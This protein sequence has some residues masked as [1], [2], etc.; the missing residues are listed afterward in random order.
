[1][2]CRVKM[3]LSGAAVP[4][5][6][7]CVASFLMYGTNNAL[8]AISPL[9]VLSLGEGMAAAGAQGTVF[10][11]A[12]IVLR[13]LLTPFAVGRR[14]KAFLLVGT[15]S[16]CASFAVLP[17]CATYESFLA[18]R[19]MQAVGLAVFWPCSTAAA[20]AL[21]DD[22]CMG[23]RLG[24]LRFVTSLS[25]MVC[26]FIAFEVADLWGYRA[27]FVGLAAAAA[28][29]SAVVAACRLPRDR[30]GSSVNDSPA[31]PARAGNGGFWST[32]RV[33]RFPLILGATL[34]V[35]VSYGLV[36]DFS[37][38]ALAANHPEL[39]EATY[40]ALFS[41]GGMVAS[42][43]GGVLLDRAP[44]GRVLP[45]SVALLAV[46]IAVLG[47]PGAS[48][49]LF[50]ASGIVAGLGNS[51]AT[52]CCLR[53]IAE[54][55]DERARSTMLGYRQNCVD[56]GIAL[57]ASGFGILLGI[58]LSFEVVFLSWAALLV[59]AALALFMRLH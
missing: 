39:N 46:G 25:L 31:V 28:G 58:P 19:V 26:P 15:G 34:L 32:L 6:L 27:L 47:A 56:I 44:W 55:P 43:V 20:M 36:S 12:A 38:V 29:S 41:F 5:A 54:A 18:I 3:R 4:F 37:P 2:G 14:L 53:A 45:A 51:A 57:S 8:M 1:M 24:V 23:R 11:A 9:F 30:D 48:G 21:S 35:A 49:A 16:F 42:L 13:F 17:L 33:A 50:V 10:L 22:A 7:L 52:L 40:L 59:A